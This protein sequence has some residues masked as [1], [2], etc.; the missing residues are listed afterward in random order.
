MV[1]YIME[2]YTFLSQM[3]TLRLVKHR[4]ED[5]ILIGM[6]FDKREPFFSN[7]RSS[8]LF[9]HVISYNEVGHREETE[10]KIIEK[11]A[12]TYTK[13]LENNELEISDLQTATVYLGYDWYACF[14]IYLEH[15]KIKFITIE[16]HPNFLITRINVGTRVYR[17]GHATLAYSNLGNKLV[18]F[19]ENREVIKRVLV[20]PNSNLS[21]NAKYIET[22]DFLKE[23]DKPHTDDKLTIISCFGVDDVFLKNNPFSILLPNGA[24]FT[25]DFFAKKSKAYLYDYL[26][27]KNKYEFLYTMLVDYFWNK[28]DP[29]LFHPHPNR[30]S[31]AM[32]DSALSKR[33]AMHLETAM[34]VEFLRWIPDVRISQAFSLETSAIDKLEGLIDEDISLGRD[35]LE[36]FHCMD[37]LYVIQKIIDKY[38][39][40]FENVF[41][42]GLPDKTFK[43]LYKCNFDK[44][45]KKKFNFFNTLSGFLKEDNSIYIVASNIKRKAPIIKKA[46][47]LRQLKKATK[48]AIVFFVNSLN[49]YSFA[50]LR[51]QDLMDYVVP[52]VINRNPIDEGKTLGD[53]GDAIIFAFCKNQEVRKIFRNIDISK[54]LTFINV[55]LSVIPIS[56]ERNE[57]E[58]RK[59]HEF[60][61]N[62]AA[63]QRIY[64][65]AM[66]M[67]N[68]R[69][70]NESDDVIKAYGSLR[71]EIML[72]QE[73]LEKREVRKKRSKKKLIYKIYQLIFHLLFNNLKG[74]LYNDD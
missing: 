66:N 39:E 47:L 14:G 55:V 27:T 9:K 29:I 45:K 17:N 1:V 53:T 32:K 57:I 65:N 52:I 56:N 63:H 64:K 11:I 41:Y 60:A 19:N 4:N 40:N 18:P 62:H 2:H 24:T 70:T 72:L 33:G 61:V 44:Y 30:P 69:V 21:G 25:N 10:E 31:G 16:A 3:L 68:L 73:K 34:P 22:Y 15:L 58:L 8:G 48:N 38:L 43:T 20:F 54:N 7:L 67:K 23:F 46:V 28:E 35:F 71:D 37:K 5:A 6:G 59:C 42:Y 49:E 74:A 36:V 12:L 26:Y 50:D 51:Q 13:L